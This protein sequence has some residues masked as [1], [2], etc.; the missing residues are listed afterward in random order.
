MDIPTIEDLEE[1][2]METLKGTV[3][4]PSSPDIFSW[5]PYTLE[6]LREVRKSLH[7]YVNRKLEPAIK[8][9]EE[10]REKAKRIINQLAQEKALK[11]EAL[12][13]EA[14]A[15]WRQAIETQKQDSVAQPALDELTA[16][17]AATAPPT[18]PAESA[19]L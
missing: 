15:H 2:Q 11:T 12:A 5:K 9:E 4:L 8:A 18:K 16:F 6:E 13:A 3:S 7:D 19:S 14:A 17:G 1:G 10:K